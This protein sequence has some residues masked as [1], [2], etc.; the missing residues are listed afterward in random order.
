MLQLLTD[1][2]QHITKKKTEHRGKKTDISRGFCLPFLT[3]GVPKLSFDD[4]LVDM[5]TFRGELDTNGSL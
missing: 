5:N 1:V 2:K 4:F 3:G